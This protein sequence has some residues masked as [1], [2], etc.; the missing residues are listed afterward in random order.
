MADFINEKAKYELVLETEAATVYYPSL[1]QNEAYELEGY[2]DDEG[3]YNIEIEVNQVYVKE[4]VEWLKSSFSG[5]KFRLTFA[6][7]WH[8]K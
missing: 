8:S 2:I 3:R 7:T 6:S 5:T 4:S 1:H